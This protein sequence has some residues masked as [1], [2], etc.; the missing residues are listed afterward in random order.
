MLPTTH[1]SC[2]LDVDFEHAFDTGNPD[3]YKRITFDNIADFSYKA[4][5]ISHYNTIKAKNVPLLESFRQQFQTDNGRVPTA[6]EEQTWWN[7]LTSAQT[8]IK[9]DL[10]GNVESFINNIISSDGTGKA[11]L[12]PATANNPADAIFASGYLIPAL[13]DYKH[14]LRWGASGTQYTDAGTGADPSKREG[15][16]RDQFHRRWIERPN[17]QTIG[18]DAFYTVRNA[19]NAPSLS[20]TPNDLRITAKDDA[21][22]LVANGVLAPKGNYLFGNFEQDGSAISRRSRKR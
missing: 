2:A 1:P 13:L 10:H 16:L 6:A 22:N 3:D 5:L 14:R 4:V 15:E 7:G 9:G 20:G 18:K 19:G 8:G 21:G 17:S 11:D 12:T